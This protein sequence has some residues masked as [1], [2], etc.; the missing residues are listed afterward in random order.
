MVCPVNPTDINYNLGALIEMPQITPRPPLASV[1]GGRLH[2]CNSLLTMRTC[3]YFD[4][5]IA[6]NNN[7]R[8][9]DVVQFQQS[10]LPRFDHGK[11]RDKYKIE[12]IHSTNSKST[13]RHSI[14]HIE[15]KVRA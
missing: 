6:F 12:R 14:F 11:Q 4:D 3:I 5:G 1:T 2:A 9:P 15:S 10:D 13:A 8:P 7:N